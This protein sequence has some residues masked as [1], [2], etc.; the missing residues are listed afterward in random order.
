MIRT[1]IIPYEVAAL[2]ER[3]PL[4]SDVVQTSKLPGRADRDTAP[5]MEYLQVAIAGD[6]E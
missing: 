5:G 6:E 1:L 2:L 3:E 4:A